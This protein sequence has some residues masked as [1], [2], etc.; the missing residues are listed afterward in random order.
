L[1]IRKAK[2][3]C[4]EGV[5]QFLSQCWDEVFW[6]KQLKGERAC[7]A[8]S[9]IEASVQGGRPAGRS[10]HIQEAES[11]RQVGPDFKKEKR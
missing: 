7:L 9:C 8:H 2:D 10:I 4:K 1:I 11:K 3:S 5:T 6:Q